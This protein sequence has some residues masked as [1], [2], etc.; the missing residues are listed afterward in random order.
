MEDF[1]SLRNFNRDEDDLKIT[2]IIKSHLTITHKWAKFLAI[3]ASIGMGL[4][5]V[6]GLIIVIVGMTTSTFGG[7]FS[8]AALGFLYLAIAALYMAPIIFLNNFSNN[9]KNALEYTNKEQLQAAFQNL[10]SLFKFLGIMTIVII[11]IYIL[12]IFAFVL[13]GVMSGGFSYF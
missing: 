1:R 7:V 5:L 10:K 4:L 13:V 8:S 12:A 6:F 11:A 2:E 9:L 3:V